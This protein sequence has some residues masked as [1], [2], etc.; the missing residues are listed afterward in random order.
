VTHQ[1]IPDYQAYMLPL[2]ELAADGE[3][4]YIRDAYR[5]IIERF[6]F[7]DEQVR[8]LLPSGTQSVIHN[9]I[10][11]AKTY[12]T[13]AGL[14]ES[15]RRAHF[16]ITDRGREVLAKSPNLI[17]KEFL[18]QYEEFVEFKSI[19]RIRRDKTGEDTQPGVEL[20]GD[21]TP[22][23]QLDAAFQAIRGS[24]AQDILDAIKGCSPAF[25]ERLVVDVLIKMGY[26]GTLE[27]PGTIVGGSGDE[28]IDGLIKEDPLGLDYI[29]IQAKQWSHTVGRPELQKFAGALQMKRARKGVFITTSEFSREAR[30]F[31]KMIDSRIILID[32][33][34]LANLMIDYNVGI[35]VVSSYDIKRLDI[36]YFEE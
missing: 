22:Q 31:V 2:L 32:G 35:S 36:D 17:T 14:L 19:S 1:D 29:Y 4:H 23:E 9:R 6:N 24:L 7:S 11:W 8:Q 28:G 3:E 10:G 12:L 21:A 18:E 30:D 27:D 15:T 5:D 25:F 26:G 20:V 13:K 16:R 34:D 33:D